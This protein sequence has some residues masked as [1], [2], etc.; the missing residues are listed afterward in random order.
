MGCV[1][2]T[3]T[4]RVIPSRNDEFKQSDCFTPGI[5]YHPSDSMVKTND[6][7]IRLKELKPGQSVKT[8]TGKRYSSALVLNT[9]YHYG[10]GYINLVEMPGRMSLHPYQYIYEDGRWIF[11]YNSKMN[12]KDIQSRVGFI[13]I[14]IDA[15]HAIVYRSPDDAENTNPDPSNGEVNQLDT[16]V[17]G[18][19]D[20]DGRSMYKHW[21]L[22]QPYRLSNE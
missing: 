6:G 18:V 20:I 15:K 7:W 5:K 17:I 10:H 22:N 19:P 1:P 14:V 2:S 13:G 11:P 8:Y 4:K 16:L 21:T 3:P 12:T 9:V